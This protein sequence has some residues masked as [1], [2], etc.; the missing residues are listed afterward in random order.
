IALLF[1]D[2]DRFK[3]VNDSLGHDAGDEVL[4]VVADRLRLGT[5]ECMTVARFG[6]DEF[7]IAA[8]H[9]DLEEARRLAGRLRAAIAAPIDLRERSLSVSASIG[10]RV[11]RRDGDPTAD[12]M[13]VAK[14]VL[15]D[16]DAAMYEAK[17]AG[18]DRT[19][20]FDLST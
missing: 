15:R 19:E 20:L 9:L 13:A 10:V 2:L 17:Q 5:D 1:L 6:G 4:C 8:P 7:V 16:A 12:A 11:W 3:L 14:A 18:R